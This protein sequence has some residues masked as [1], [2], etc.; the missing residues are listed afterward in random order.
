MKTEHGLK[1]QYIYRLVLDGHKVVKEEVILRESGRVR[2][3]KTAPD[4]SIYVLTDRRGMI[5]HL[6]PEN[7]E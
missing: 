7:N 3:I 1:H 5:L 6:T 2:D 4:G